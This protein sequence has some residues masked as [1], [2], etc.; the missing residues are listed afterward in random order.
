MRLNGAASGGFS[1]RVLAP[2][3]ARY[4]VAGG[5][6]AG[7]ERELRL[8]PL[9]CD[10]RSDAVDVGANF[11]AYT[12]FM[13]RWS[14]QC[15]AFEPQ[16]ACAAWLREAFPDCVVEEVALSDVIGHAVLRIPVESGHVVETGARIGIEPISG[17]SGITPDRPSLAVDVRTMPLDSYQ[18]A[19]VGVIKIDTEGHELAVIAGGVRM[20][21]SSKPRI[22]VEC[23][24]RHRLGALASVLDMLSGLGYIGCCRT[25]SGWDRF[26]SADEGYGRSVTNNF[27]F[28]HGSDS[29]LAALGR[30]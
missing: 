18:L 20:I 10:K 25:T 3:L 4:I 14:R 27:V 22:I 29:A 2:R 26:G 11:G 9:L 24:E 12:F 28:I 23:E 17:A 19:D 15:Y 7:G 21:Q 30:G 1:R 5:N 16:P 8:L 6:W 13:R